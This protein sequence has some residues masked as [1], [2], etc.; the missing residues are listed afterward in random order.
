LKSRLLDDSEIA[1]AYGALPGGIAQV[2]CSG[3]KE[4]LEFDNFISWQKMVEDTVD[5]LLVIEK[6]RSFQ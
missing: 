3:M 5:D 4:V 6:G 2:D 1:E